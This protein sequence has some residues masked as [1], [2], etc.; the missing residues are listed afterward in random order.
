MSQHIINNP[1][2]VQFR[3]PDGFKMAVWTVAQRE[4][5]SLAAFLRKI[6]SEAVRA[7]NCD[8]GQIRNGFASG[9]QMSMHTGPTGAMALA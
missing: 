7:A 3:A 1:E 8:E 2:V 6:A 9:R 4:G 5:L